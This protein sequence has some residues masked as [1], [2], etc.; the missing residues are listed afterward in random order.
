VKA[1]SVVQ[2][3]MRFKHQNVDCFDKS[4]NLFSNGKEHHEEGRPRAKCL[5][6]SKINSLS[7]Q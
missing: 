6:I 1:T 7:G 5:C 3:N 2:C 4:R